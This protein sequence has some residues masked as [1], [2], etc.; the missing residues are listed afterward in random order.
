M[1]ETR[2]SIV[3]KVRGFLGSPFSEKLNALEL[4]YYR[5]KGILYYRYIFASFGRGS[6]LYKP[7][8]LSNPR[9]MHV[10]RNVTIRHG[11]R[12]EAIVTD[13]KNP[14]EL[15]IGN[16]VNIEQNAHIVCHSNVVIGNDVSITG[17]CAIVDVTHPFTDVH[18]PL[19]I[20]DRIKKERSHVE[21]GDR[22]FLGFGVIVLPNV[23]IGRYC[24][25]GAHSLVRRDT[26]DYSV[27]AG[28]PATIRNRYDAATRVW[29]STAAST[30]RK[31]PSAD[32]MNTEDGDYPLP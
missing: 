32:V 1:T 22:S 21:I 2:R 4:A 5:V 30:E 9:F 31:E 12:L 28:N 29:S 27:V 18:E 13:K 8:I 19:K 15:R 26:P 20:G 24:I 17:N 3:G 10:G 25:V 16:N 14:P 23:R 6:V 11:A 7:I